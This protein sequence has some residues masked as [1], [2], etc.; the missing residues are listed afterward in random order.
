LGEISVKS[1]FPTTI[2]AQRSPDAP[3]TGVDGAN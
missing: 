1:G 2:S 3:L